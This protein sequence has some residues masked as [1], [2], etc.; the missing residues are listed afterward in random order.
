M[1]LKYSSKEKIAGVFVICSVLLL[2]ITLVII[3]RGKDWFKK[4]VSYYTVFDESY[5]VQ[6]DT[7]VKLLETNIGKVKK[8]SLLGDR[9]RVEL[10]ILEEYASRIRTGTAVTVGSPTFIGSEYV[11]IKPGKEKDAPLIPEG[12]LIPSAPR[13][14][15]SDLL[16]EFEVEKT[17]KMVV[18]AVQDISELVHTLRDP[19]GPLFRILN[20]TSTAIGHVE[21]LARDLQAGKGTAGALLKS[22]R[23]INAIHEN[24][25]KIG[26]ILD[27]IETTASTFPRKSDRIDGIL[28]HIHEAAAKTPA[29]MDK[30][31][32]NLET[33]QAA[34]EGLT[35]NIAQ[36]KAI[37]EEVKENLDA[38]RVIL[39]NLE[40]ASFDVPTVTQ[41]TAEGIKEV[42]ESIDNIDKVVKSL[43]QNFL[44]RPNLPPEPVGKNTDAGLRE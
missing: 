31:Q 17:A 2:I 38:F 22:N 18:K 25:K 13:R 28:D 24:L 43:Q 9:V 15:I 14:S 32:D 42:R 40:K 30:V 10:L 7:A 12:G 27:H 26:T 29:A 20:D 34:G 39:K 21:S 19:E 36:I 33:I 1:E 44:I 6:E 41:S 4:Y 35:E 11:S 8:V 16:E 5:N 37:L 23:L 3:G